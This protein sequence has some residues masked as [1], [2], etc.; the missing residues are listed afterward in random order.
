MELEPGNEKALQG[1]ARSLF[2][3]GRYQE[4]LEAYDQLLTLQP[5]KKH[6]I[7]NRAVCQTNTGHYG[8]ALKDL[9]RL[10]FESPDDTTVNR[11][12]AWTLTCNEK[13]E[14]AEKIYAQLLTDKPLPDDLLNYGYC[15]WLAGHVDEAADCFHRYLKETKQQKTFIIENELD[16]LREKGI[17]E[18]EMQMMLYIL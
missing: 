12:L 1:Y 3:L 2:D 13:Y 10:N 9:Y 8:E 18:P 4:A 14:Q 7:L 11:V 5:E 6:Y 15:M 16:L 17:T